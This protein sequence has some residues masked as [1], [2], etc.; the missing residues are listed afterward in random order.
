[1]AVLS[2]EDKRVQGLKSWTAI[3]L[4]RIVISRHEDNN[5]RNE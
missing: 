3:P 5:A 4:D 1:M 2:L